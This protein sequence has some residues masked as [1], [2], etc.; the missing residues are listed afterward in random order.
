MA[1]KPFLYYSVCMAKMINKKIDISI[2]TPC[3]NEELNVELCA[4][5]LSHEMNRQLPGTNYEHIFVDNNSSD[6]TFNKLLALSKKDKRIKVIRNSKNVGSFYNMW[7][8]MQNCRGSYVVPLLPADLQ[9]PPSQIPIMYKTLI[10]SK[11]LIAYGVIERREEK[12]LM[13]K[14]RELYYY[15]INKLAASH[16]P[17]N[18]GEFLIA[19]YRV[20]NSVLMTNDNN[21]YLR[22]LFAQTGVKAIA[23]PYT[24]VKRKFGKS[25]ESALTLFNAAV[26]GFIST[27]TLLPRIILVFG[28]F[29]ALISVLMSIFN[30]ASFILNGTFGTQ[31]G[32]PTLLIAV[33][34][35]SGIQLLFLGLAT[36]YIQAL[37]KQVRPSPKSFITDKVNFD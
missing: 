30:L 25:K 33:F 22:G 9:D 28:L 3:F 32:V 26:N 16:I 17:R 14:S 27:S 37:Y 8:G 31:S 11:S 2:V 12:Y 6:S 18:S 34:F 1:P 20:V 5:K 15:L 23:V 36:E 19:D 10:K 35:L 21:P 7:I 13:R 4:K 29:T 24:K